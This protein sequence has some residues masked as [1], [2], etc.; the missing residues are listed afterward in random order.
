MKPKK[1]SCKANRSINAVL[2]MYYTDNVR[3]LSIFYINSHLPFD[4]YYLLIEKLHNTLNWIQL[5]RGRFYSVSSLCFLTET[6]CSTIS[7]LIIQLKIYWTNIPIRE[8][9]MVCGKKGRW[10]SHGPLLFY[11]SYSQG[12]AIIYTVYKFPFAF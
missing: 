1:W 2:I 8:C 11:I 4:S 9:Y 7:H 12:L 5:V 3:L 10:T 6:L